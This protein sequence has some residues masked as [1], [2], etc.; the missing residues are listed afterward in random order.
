M[1]VWPGIVISMCKPVYKEEK[2]LGV[3]AV[4]L[5]LADLLTEATYYNGGEYSYAFII[6]RTGQTLVH[7]LLPKPSVSETGR[8]S[9]DMSALEQNNVVQHVIDS[10]K[11]LV[12]Y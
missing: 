6:D 11:K 1:H 3:A 10:M 9:V 8:A 5:R 4:D 2:L 7:P 12:I